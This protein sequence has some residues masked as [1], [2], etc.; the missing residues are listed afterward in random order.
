MSVSTNPI[1]TGW[2]NENSLREYPFH[3]GVGL[4]PVSSAG[5]MVD[6]GWTLP[7]CLIVDMTVSVDGGDYDPFMYLASM[8]VAGGAAT[9]SF[10]GRNGGIMNLY[11]NAETHVKNQ[12]YAI[13]GEESLHGVVAHVCIGDFDAFLEQTPDGVYTFL[14]E[15]TQIEPTCIRPSLVDVRSI[16]VVD[17]SGYSSR[18]IV[19]NVVLV[20][21]ENVRFDFQPGTNSIVMSADPN[22][23]YV[24]KCD[25]EDVGQRTVRS[26]N[27]ISVDKVTIV[28]DDCVQ[29]TSDAGVIRIS[30][31]CA[32]PCCGCAETVFINQTV[33]DLQTS[34]NTLA[35]NVSA[36]SGRLQDFITSYALGRK[37]LM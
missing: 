14:P 16:T 7:N 10:S 18:P 13:Q 27:G 6:E 25:C 30:D 12:T 8:S 33:N 34:V 11:V 17:K 26:I 5:N 35:G 15:E 32:K 3:E 22:S 19:G 4:R 24:E 9:L 1:A 31:T 28:G 2:L 21:G 23:G 37:T 29:V 36:L 20:A